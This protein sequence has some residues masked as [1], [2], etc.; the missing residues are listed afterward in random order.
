MTIKGT[1]KKYFSDK[2]F[3]FIER[4]KGGNDVHFGQDSF[5]GQP[6]QVGEMVEFEVESRKQ[7]DH[8]KNI[9]VIED[10]TTKFLKEN[11]LEIEDKDYDKFCDE[12]KDFALKL[13]NGGMT[14]S[15][16]RKIYSR[17]MN[18]E[19]ASELKMLRPQFAYT[20]GR[21]EG[22]M[23]LKKFMDL[24]DYLVKNMELENK[25]HMEN[26]KNFMEAVVAYRKY[27]E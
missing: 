25:E 23:G 2:G 6:P 17:I 15:Q 24:L 18:A 21:Q 16:I 22:V 5:T 26:F 10:E 7:G 27:V 19:S 13:K 12:T 20:V 8:A 1:V 4:S 3:G 11:V 9:K 14:P